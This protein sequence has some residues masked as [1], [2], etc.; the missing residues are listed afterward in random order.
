LK[1]QINKRRKVHKNNTKPKMLYL[2]NIKKK[3]QPKKTPT[4]PPKKNKRKT[5]THNDPLTDEQ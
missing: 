1:I 3:K 5:K 4:R 2:F